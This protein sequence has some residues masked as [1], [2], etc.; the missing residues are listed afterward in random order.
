MTVTKKSRYTIRLAIKVDKPNNNNVTYSKEAV[1]DI[2]NQ[3]KKR[4]ENFPISWYYVDGGAAPE[5]RDIVAY[6]YND[7]IEVRENGDVAIDIGLLPN[8][9]EILSQLIEEDALRLGG[10]Y[11]IVDSNATV[12]PSLLIKLL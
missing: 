8:C 5:K 11:K 4:Q 9:I 2:A 10:V 1:L 6:T 7:S 3:I 12:T